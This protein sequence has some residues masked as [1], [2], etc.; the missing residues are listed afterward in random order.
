MLFWYSLVKYFVVVYH[1]LSDM[2]N[3][4][5]DNLLN[6]VETKVVW[7]SKLKQ[8]KVSVFCISRL[9]VIAD[10]TYCLAHEAYFW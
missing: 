7:F 2:L 10:N 9:V 6:M 1:G 5:N 8:L 3:L 4:E